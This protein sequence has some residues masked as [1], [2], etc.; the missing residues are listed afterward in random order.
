MRKLKRNIL[1]SLIMLLFVGSFSTIEASAAT[2]V[3]KVY[4]QKCSGV[5]DISAK[6]SKSSTF[7]IYTSWIKYKLNKPYKKYSRKKSISLTCNLSNRRHYYVKIVSAKKAKTSCTIK[8]HLDKKTVNNK[9]IKWIAKSNSG[10]PGGSIIYIKK[11]YFSKSQVAQ[12]LEYVD[13]NKV[14]DNQTTL[15]NA[16][17]FAGSTIL[18]TYT[19]SKFIGGLF[20]AVSGV[21]VFKGINFKDITKEQ[22][23]DASGY[24]YN[25]KT[26]KGTAQ[27]GVLIT[28]YYCEGMEMVSVEGWNGSSVSGVKGYSGNWSY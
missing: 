10:V 14:L 1:M 6:S 3:K 12:A 25:S 4:D 9:G 24:S 19:G 2:T 23:K 13:E 18:T 7:Y 15:L 16:T 26:G 8:Q 17:W 28:I 5:T 11:L 20:T 27:K 21:Q 22:V